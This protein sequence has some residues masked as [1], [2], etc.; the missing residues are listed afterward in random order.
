MARGKNKAI[1]ER[2]NEAMAEIGSI[3]S[4]RLVIRN[5]QNK[6]EEL[7]KK[8]ETQAQVHAETVAGMYLRLAENTSEVVEEL[9]GLNDSLL[10]ELGELRNSNEKVLKNWGKVFINLSSHFA[11]E[12]GMKRLEAM[13]HATALMGDDPSETITVDIDG[14]AKHSKLT[15][16]RLRTLQKI[17][18]LR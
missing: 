12:H 4:Q 14:N 1:A 15:T 6:I 2:R 7:E 16:E 13:E 17:R 11:G 3:E 9:R 10:E 5:Q 18:G 8:L